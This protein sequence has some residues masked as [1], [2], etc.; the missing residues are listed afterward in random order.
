[1]NDFKTNIN[2]Y[3]GHMTRAMRKM[4][5]DVKL[6]D[7]VIELVDS[8]VPLSSENP[9]IESLTRGK[10]RLLIMNKADLADP[11][12]SEKWAGYYAG[13]KVDVILADSRNSSG[14]KE[15][16]A[17]INK[18]MAEKKARDL[19]RG[20][21]NRPLRI[22][23]AGIP[24]VGKSTLINTL[25]KKAVAKT[26]DKPGVTK[27]NQWIKISKGV[28]LLDTPGVLWP[29]FEDPNVGVRLAL[30]GSINDNVIPLGDL[31]CNGLL[32]LRENYSG[33]LNKTYGISEEGSPY[34]LL[35]T[36]AKARNLLKTGALPDEERA[37]KL[38]LTDL[39]AG[40]LGRISLETPNL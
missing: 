39:R 4:K 9:D 17:A 36:L 8:R 6:V 11:D 32:F 28:E 18:S 37:A 23:V 12:V 24:N 16:E 2:W 13:K 19:S 5:E 22:L 40:R 30:I 35:I 25:A 27:G 20:I 26:G 1:M 3:P 21:L 10:K 31:A 33:C 14:K 34:E 38:F 7:L 29:K 15:I